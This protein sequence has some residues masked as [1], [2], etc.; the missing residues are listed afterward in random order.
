MELLTQSDAGMSV[1][2]RYSY[3]LPCTVE[4]IYLLLAPDGASKSRNS[5][6]AQPSISFPTDVNSYNYSWDTLFNRLQRSLLTPNF[7]V[8]ELLMKSGANANA[9]NLHNMTP[10][11]FLLSSSVYGREIESEP[12]LTITY[13]RLQL[14][15]TTVP[16]R[17][18][19][20]HKFLDTPLRG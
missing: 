15:W 6:F 12:Y 7:D 18:R 19:A 17:L 8:V 1:C 11:V 14:C 4:T 16:E 10:Y 9:R 2:N 13:S 20:S 3:F 5:N